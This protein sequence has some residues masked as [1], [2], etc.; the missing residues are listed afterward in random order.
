SVSR[1]VIDVGVSIARPRKSRVRGVTLVDSRD[2]QS[3]SSICGS[4]AQLLSEQTHL[5]ETELRMRPVHTGLSEAC[6]A[7]G[8]NFDIRQL[9]GDPLHLLAAEARYQDLIVIPSPDGATTWSS[10]QTCV[11]SHIDIVGLLDRS[12][13]PML[14]LRKEARSFRRVLLT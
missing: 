12:V 4:A 6:I 10:G 8:L 3:L 11:F 7:A 9:S 2:F 13:Q 1:A 5:R 14:V